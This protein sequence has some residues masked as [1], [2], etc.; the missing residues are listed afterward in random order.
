VAPEHRCAGSGFYDFVVHFRGAFG[1]ASFGR[2][3]LFAFTAN[4]GNDFGGIE[5]VGVDTDVAEH[6]LGA[7]LPALITIL[8]EA[9]PVPNF[10]FLLFSAG[11]GQ[12]GSG[13]R[14]AGAGGK[15]RQRY[16]DQWNR[17]F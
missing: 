7:S 10:L 12:E 2:V 13:F 5:D 1:G 17:A 3:A 15:D 9:P 16:R 14:E 11:A 8:I 4:I 6:T